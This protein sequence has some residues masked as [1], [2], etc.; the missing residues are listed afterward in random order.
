VSADPAALGRIERI[1]DLGL[2]PEAQEV[3]RSLTDYGEDRFSGQII[4]ALFE[5]QKKG[6]LRPVLDVVETWYR[7]LLVRNHPD[8]M[9]SVRWAA[10]GGS[11]ES[12]QAEELV[13]RFAE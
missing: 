8:Y 5:A 9:E 13:A 2:P 6:D 1:E 12:Y 11:G 3:L 7:T 4:Q 10:D